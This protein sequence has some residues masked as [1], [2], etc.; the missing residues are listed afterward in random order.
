MK[1]HKIWLAISGI[2][3]IVLGVLC[4]A[5]PA[6]TLFTTAWM[7]GC[8]TLFSGITKMVFAFRT[9][10]FMPNSGTRMLSGLLQIILGLI[11]LTH[12]MFVAVSLPLVFVM[13]VIFE[14]ITL[15]IQSFEYKK[16]GF[17]KWWVLLLLG[18]IIALLGIL[19]MRYLD[20]AGMTLTLMIGIGIIILGLAN[21]F[22]L[23]SIN[24]FEK[25]V[26]KANEAVMGE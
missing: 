25:Q 19:G 15:A 18:I 13:W 12:N 5:E 11:F 9:E 3:L 8:F 10:H 1:N 17:T 22:A 2:L 14:G 23:S 7:I 16:F 4:I 6:A 24:Q 21:L 20:V 26:K